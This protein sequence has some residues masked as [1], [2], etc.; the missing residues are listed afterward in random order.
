MTP[1]DV[2]AIGEAVADGLA[3]VCDVL[4]RLL[5][6]IEHLERRVDLLERLELERL[7]RQDDTAARAAGRTIP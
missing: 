7:Y 1:E 2:A 6:V 5:T 3:P 4:G